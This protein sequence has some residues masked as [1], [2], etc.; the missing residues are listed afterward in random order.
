[1][2]HDGE[3][4]N[5]SCTR[6]HKILLIYAL[7]LSCISFQTVQCLIDR[8]QGY[9]SARFAPA[10]RRHILLI[11]HLRRHRVLWTLLTAVSKV[12]H[13]RAPP[14]AASTMAWNPSTPLLQTHRHHILLIRHLL[15]RRV[16]RTFLVTV[17]IVTHHHV[18][19]TAASTMARNTSTPLLQPHRRHILLARHLRRRRSRFLRA[20][21]AAAST[22]T[23]Q[24]SATPSPQLQRRLLL[25]AP[26]PA[27]MS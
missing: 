20:L 18:P 1:M 14:T 24:P 11:R 21:L 5:F 10:H 22:M 16:L 27:T 15:R 13:Q 6:H 25:R 23:R 2:L 9:F 19:P 7:N 12:T 26:T 3:V 8:A 17:S 4:A